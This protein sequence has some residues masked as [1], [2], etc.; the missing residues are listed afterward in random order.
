MHADCGPRSRLQAIR[1]LEVVK[2]IARLRF[3]IQVGTIEGTC[4]VFVRGWLPVSRLEESVELTGAP[5][6]MT[7]FGR[8]SFPLAGIARTPTLVKLRCSPFP[9]LQVMLFF[10]LW[11]GRAIY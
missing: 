1:E 8:Y 9:Q 7:I 10:L 3:V 5:L 2:L 11:R 6:I 4:V